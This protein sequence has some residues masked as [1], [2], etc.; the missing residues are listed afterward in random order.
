MRREGDAAGS[1]VEIAGLSLTT[2][3]ASLTIDVAESRRLGS[4]ESKEN[5]I[6]CDVKFD[7][8]FMFMSSIRPKSWESVPWLVSWSSLALR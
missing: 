5:V 3:V 2:G 8:G 6:P 4:T 7:M 1:S